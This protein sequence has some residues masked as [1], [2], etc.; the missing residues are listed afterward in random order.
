ML[1][2]DETYEDYH[3]RISLTNTR[4]KSTATS[5]PNTTTTSEGSLKKDNSKRKPASSGSS[6]RESSCTSSNSGSYKRCNEFFDNIPELEEEEHVP[7]FDRQ[8]EKSKQRTP[9][10]HQS[11][12]GYG[13]ESSDLSTNPYFLRRC[14]AY[15]RQYGIRPDFFCQYYKAVW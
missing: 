15:M 3:R 13:D 2:P 11:S 12:N 1:F 4:S 8:H 9:K 10:H 6:E 5:L 14:E 7:H